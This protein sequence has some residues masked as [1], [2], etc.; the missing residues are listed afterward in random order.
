MTST[1]LALAHPHGAA[2]AGGSSTHWFAIGLLVGVLAVFF[3]PA[4]LMSL[5]V[6][7]DLVALG[8]SFGILR[9]T[10]TAHGRWVLI[11]V[12]FLLLGLYFGVIRGLRLLSNHE[13]ATRFSG[14]RARG[15]Y[16]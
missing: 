6:I 11:A 7:F 4:W 1:V 15:W 8:W 10:H 14:I 13:L 2:S 5:I 16:L 9:Y 3:A 12:P